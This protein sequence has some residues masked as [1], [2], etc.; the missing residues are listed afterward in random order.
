[1]ADDGRDKLKRT[2]DRAAE[3]YYKARPD[4]PDQMCRRLLILADR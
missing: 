3:L 1:M 4:Y 2:F